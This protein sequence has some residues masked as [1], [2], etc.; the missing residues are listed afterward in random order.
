MPAFADG[1]ADRLVVDRDGRGAT[2]GPIHLDAVVVPI[3]AGPREHGHVVALEA[4]GGPVSAG[5]SR[6]VEQPR[7]IAGAYDQAPRA[8]T[9]D[10]QLALLILAMREF[11]HRR[12]SA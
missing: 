1:A 11:D 7:A 6:P 9:I 12:G 2:S 3:L 8:A 4:V 5:L 10:V